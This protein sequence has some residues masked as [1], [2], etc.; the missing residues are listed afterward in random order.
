MFT[1]STFFPRVFGAALL[2]DEKA[3]GTCTKIRISSKTNARAYQV[4]I[5]I[6]LLVFSFAVA[7]TKAVSAPCWQLEEFVVAKECSACEGFHS[8]SFWDMYT[9]A[10]IKKFMVS[11]IYLILLTAH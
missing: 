9:H 7:V 2:S 4:H 1:L 5:L 3:T 6:I 8:V 11:K 10:H